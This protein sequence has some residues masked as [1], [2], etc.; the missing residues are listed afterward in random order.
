[1]L[2]I[3]FPCLSLY[4]DQ[5]QSILCH[6]LSFHPSVVAQV[7][8]WLSIFVC[9]SRCLFPDKNPQISLKTV[10]RVCLG[11]NHLNTMYMKGFIISVQKTHLY[12][13]FFTRKPMWFSLSSRVFF[14]ASTTLWFSKSSLW[15]RWLF[16]SRVS[17]TACTQDNT[18]HINWRD[19]K[20]LGRQFCEES[21]LTLLSSKLSNGLL[22]STKHRKCLTASLRSKCI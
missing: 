14:N 3:L 9:V 8:P 20:P 19:S 16:S 21:D 11:G 2:F 22:W 15:R 7:R 1:M 17:Q 4:Q 13:T 6:H 5:L 12:L 18:Q 10:T